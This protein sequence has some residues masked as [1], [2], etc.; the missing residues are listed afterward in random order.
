MK[1]KLVRVEGIIGYVPTRQ[2]IEEEIRQDD[3]KYWA[4]KPEPKLLYD[5]RPMKLRL[6]DDDKYLSAAMYAFAQGIHFIKAIPKL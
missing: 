6:T 3:L 5:Y 2:D 1:K 4:S